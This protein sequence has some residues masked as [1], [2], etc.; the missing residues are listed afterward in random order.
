MTGSDPTSRSPALA[1]CAH[2]TEVPDDILGNVDMHAQDLAIYIKNTWDIQAA[3]KGWREFL[4]RAHSENPP[5]P[6]VEDRLVEAVLSTFTGVNTETVTEFG[7]AEECALPRVAYEN[8]R[9]TPALQVLIEASIKFGMHIE[10]ELRKRAAR[11]ARARI[12]RMLP[13]VKDQILAEIER[14]VP[15]NK[16]DEP[17]TAD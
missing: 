13:D 11:E 3:P 16:F 7:F 12:A 15:V 10:H 9:G 2:I 4:L 14:I 8:R 6:E 5:S 1:H 17:Q